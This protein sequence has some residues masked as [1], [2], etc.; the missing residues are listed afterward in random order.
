M[1][2]AVPVPGHRPAAR[3]AVARPTARLAGAC[4]PAAAVR[5]AGRPARP[6]DGPGAGG[7]GLGTAPRREPGADGGP[8]SHPARPTAGRGAGAA[9][10]L[11]PARRSHPFRPAVL[12]GAGGGRTRRRNAAARIHRSHRRR[13]HRRAAGGRLQDR[14]G[15]AGCTSPGRVQGHVPDEVLR[16]GPVAFARCAAHPAAAHLSG[17]RSG[18]GLL[19]RVRRAAALREDP[20][21]DLAGHP[22]RR[23]DRRFPSHP[24][25]AVRLVSASA[26]L[27]AIRRNP[28]ALPRLAG[29]LARKTIRLCPTPSTW[30]ARPAATFAAASSGSVR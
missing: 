23:S 27:P 8:G 18:A 12:R 9:R 25:T 3:G 29:N 15:A 5:A 17:R 6:R 1:P 13:R 7:P 2:A 21:G 4:R 16:G 28:A 22:I 26:A 11:L 30:P 24:V 20:D 10:R 14:Q 19:T